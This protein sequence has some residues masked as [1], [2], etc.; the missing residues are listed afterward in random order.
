MSK[1]HFLIQFCLVGKYV[2]ANVQLNIVHIWRMLTS[3]IQPPVHDAMLDLHVPGEI[4]LQCEL[5]RT[6]ETFEGLAVRVE[7][8]VAHQVVHPVELLAAKLESERQRRGNE[9]R[10]WLLLV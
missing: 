3:F 8:H 9:K 2:H 6:V 4:P 7:M 1:K 5:A 10:V